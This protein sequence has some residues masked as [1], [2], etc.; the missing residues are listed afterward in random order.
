MTAQLEEL[1]AEQNR[2]SKNRRGAPTPEEREQLA[3]LAAR[4]RAL[5]DELTQVAGERDRL[6][7]SLPNLPADDAPD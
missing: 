7:A 3:E 1:R 2:A 5:S 4:G 6:L